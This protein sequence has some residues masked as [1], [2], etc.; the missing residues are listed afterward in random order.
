LAASSVIKVLFRV[1]EASRQRPLPALG[2]P[3]PPDQQHAETALA[4]GQRDHVH[5]DAD[6][7]KAPRII[8]G[9]ELLLRH[10]RRVGHC[11]VPPALAT[12]DDQGCATMA[13]GPAWML[14]SAGGSRIFVRAW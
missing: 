8:A 5:G 2:V 14:S 11:R 9:Q 10:A 7:R 1:D 4:H 13:G 12:R 6:R 3:G